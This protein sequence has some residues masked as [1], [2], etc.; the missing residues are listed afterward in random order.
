M[1]VIVWLGMVLGLLLAGCVS[2]AMETKASG[3]VPIPPGKG[4]LVLQWTSEQSRSILG[5]TWASAN[6]DVYEGIL[7]GSAETK[8]FDLTGGSGQ[9]VAVD[10]G[11]Y[12]FLVLAGVK[13]S[14]A[15][16]TAYMVGSAL[17]ETVSVVAGQRTSVNLVLKSI[18]LSWATTG[19]AYWKGS[20]GVSASGKSRNPR[21]GMSLAGTS[22]T[23][24]P[25][26]KSDLWNGYKEAATVTG[27]PDDWSFEATGTVP[28]AVPSLKIGLV[29]AGLVIQGLDGTWTPLAGVA[30]HS[31]YWPNRPDLA[32]NHP[33]V[34]ATELTVTCGAAPTGIQVGVGW[35]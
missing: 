16:L 7:Q 28:D 29:G 21:L 13:R 24:R 31:W 30:R 5:S 15:A 3:D 25:R 27:T 34:N 19:A 17:A 35:E 23:A 12:R 22:T 32:D 11:T 6:A 2:P 33:L 18:D 10:P 14:P 8:Y 26:F 4:Q 20:L 1:R 9:A